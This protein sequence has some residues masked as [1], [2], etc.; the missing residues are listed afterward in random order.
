M[1]KQFW[2]KPRQVLIEPLDHQQ[3][4]LMLMAP[5][6]AL[7]TQNLEVMQQQP[8]RITPSTSQQHLD[9][10]IQPI[11]SQKVFTVVSSTPAHIERDQ[12]HQTTPFPLQQ[13]ITPPPELFIQRPPLPQMAIAP[14]M[15]PKPTTQPW[16]QLQQQNQAHKLIMQLQTPSPGLFAY[17]AQPQQPQILTQ[18]NPV[19]ISIHPQHRASLSL[20]SISSLSISNQTQNRL[21]QPSTQLDQHI[22]LNQGPRFIDISDLCE[23]KEEVGKGGSGIVYKAITNDGMHVALKKIKLKSKEFVKMAREEVEI[24]QKLRGRSGII[25]LLNNPPLT[26]FKENAELELIFEWGEGGDMAQRLQKHNNQKQSLSSASGQIRYP[27]MPS[28]ELQQCWREMLESISQV[29]SFGRGIVH[30]D[31]KPANF[32]FVEGKLKL[33][34]FGIAKTIEDNTVHAQQQEGVGTYNYISPEALGW[35][36]ADNGLPDNRVKLG[37]ES[38]IWSLGMI[39]YEMIFGKPY[40]SNLRSQQKVAA[41]ISEAQVIIPPVPAEIY[42][43]KLLLEKI[44]IKD[45]NKR[46]TIQQLL[47]NLIPQLQ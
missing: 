6:S 37:L 17:P 36:K 2:K 12:F 24:L 1:S 4:N 7:I 11:K 14:Q 21:Q 33:I 44:L 30:G 40:Y 47:T 16:P 46:P 43:Y 5:P 31:L 23:E 34:D 45:P 3:K 27:I 28:L 15:T 32:L 22:Q 18:P 39:L 10:Q 8:Q 25:Q 35:G 38:D 41:I 26:Q 9:P 42:E 20:P 29:H 19:Q 13:S